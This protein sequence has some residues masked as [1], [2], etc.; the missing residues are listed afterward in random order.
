[1]L[2]DINFRL[3]NNYFTPSRIIVFPVEKEKFSPEEETI[4][5]A[6]SSG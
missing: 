3:L 4:I 1:M 2:W 6:T 5:L